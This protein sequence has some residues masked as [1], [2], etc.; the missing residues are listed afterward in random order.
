MTKTVVTVDG[1]EIAPDADG[2][3]SIQNAEL[4]TYE[5]TASAYDEAENVGTATAS[6]PVNEA[7]AP[8]ITVVFDKENYSEG[9]DLSALIT[10]EGQREIKEIKVLVNGEEKTLEE[11]G[12]F[13]IES[14]AAGEYVFN[15]TAEDVK[16]FTSECE[17]TVTVLPV[18]TEDKRLT[19][20]I[21]P[22][23][24]YGETA[25]LTVK[26]TDEINAESLKVVLDDEEISLTSELTYEFNAEKLFAHNFVITAQTND[27]EA[28]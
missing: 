13:K 27:G 19:A 22:F 1:T 6:V 17:K 11:G 24:E 15:I 28:I 9:D 12:V 25:L 5:I 8:V 23:V 10:A 4:K 14:I 26:I 16:G 18:D 3:Y 2:N 21:E 20:E 7:S